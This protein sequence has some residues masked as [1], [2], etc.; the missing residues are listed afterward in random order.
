MS[1]K[2]RINSNPSAAASLVKSGLSQVN[3]STSTARTDS[4]LFPSKAQEAATPLFPRPSPVSVMAVI[5][6]VACG[7]GSSFS[8]GRRSLSRGGPDEDH[9]RRP[10][11]DRA[12]MCPTG[13]GGFEHGTA[14]VGRC[15]WAYSLVPRHELLLQDRARC[16]RLLH[17]AARSAPQKLRYYRPAPRFGGVSMSIMSFRTLAVIIL[18]ATIA[19]SSTT[20]QAQN[21]P[22]ATES[23]SPAAGV[24]PPAAIAGNWSGTVIQVQRSIEYA[25]SL[26][27]DDRG[28]QSSYPGLNCGGTL[29]RVG[30]SAGYVF[31]VETITRGPVHNDG[32]CSSGTIT[33]ARTGDKLA[34]A[35]FGLVHGEIVAAH[36]LLT[37]RREATQTEA[38][39]ITGS[40]NPS[41]PAPLPRRRARQE[42]RAPKAPPLP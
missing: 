26:A 18:A 27:I 14:V 42:P 6:S 38:Q 8:A 23:A 9:G 21:A 3:K 24:Q 10:K 36:G 35:W 4:R 20:A 15:S 25:V 40:T 34:W 19:T 22:P 1:W 37:R 12:F 11:G 39:S 2:P 7:T 30:A 17:A 41:P 16:P 28:A 32:M 5:I 31:F 29:K 13:D 33:T